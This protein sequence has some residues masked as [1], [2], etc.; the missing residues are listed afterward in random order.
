MK[1]KRGKEGLVKLSRA[2][3]EVLAD[4]MKAWFMESPDNWWIEEFAVM[5]QIPYKY[6][7]DEFA[8]KSRYWSEVMD[9]CWGMQKVRFFRLAQEK[10]LP[11]TV[12]MLGARNILDWR[13]GRERTV[14]KGEAKKQVFSKEKMNRLKLL[15]FPRGKKAS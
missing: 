5:K 15:R 8:D 3:I 10:K 6:F 9:L 12:A 1:P 14:G 11:S 4:E 7:T 13:D 2:Q